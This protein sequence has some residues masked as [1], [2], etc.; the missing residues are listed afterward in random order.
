MSISKL[1]INKVN[2]DGVDGSGKSSLIK[3]LKKEYPH[4]HINDRDVLS[5]LT[6]EYQLPPNIE[7]KNT[8]SLILDADMNTLISR[9]NKR[10]G[11]KNIFDSP[12]SLFKYRKRFQ[13]LA[14]KYQT[15]YIDTS[16]MSL[17]A[18]L[19]AATVIISAWTKTNETK[20]NGPEMD[21]RLL[22][23]E[24]KLPNPDCVTEEQ[25]NKLELIIQ[26][27]YKT[28]RRLNNKFSLIKMI[29]VD[30][31]SMNITRNLLYMFDIECIPHSYWYVGDTYILCEY[32]DPSKDVPSIE[33][34]VA[35]CCVKN[36]QLKYVGIDNMINRF[37]KHVVDE[38]RQREYKRPFVRF[39][40]RIN[41]TSSEMSYDSTYETLYEDLADEF[42]DTMSA[43]N[44]ALRTFKVLDKHF[45][46][47]GLYL[48]ETCS[49][50]TTE[51]KTHYSEIHT[52]QMGLNVHDI[53]V[54]YME[55]IYAS[56]LMFSK[57]H[58]SSKDQST[59]YIEKVYS[60]VVLRKN[61]ILN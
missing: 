18:V 50:I 10:G 47:M 29:D 53:L 17:E 46:R 2:I 51:G 16:M 28:I 36:D 42:I 26:T 30:K 4:L 39:C 32:L 9:I 12:P 21:H 34:V 14:I 57:S 7:C 24:Y 22:C 54:I 6:D 58:D 43:R 44:L 59:S 41:K 8:L 15:Y 1:I 35:K 25:F 61:E 49:M 31:D 45:E 20:N 33:T 37:G 56:I 5:K 40:Y 23:D 55:K 27:K 3:L 13:R 48:E 11:P 19:E 38:N 60:S 52:K